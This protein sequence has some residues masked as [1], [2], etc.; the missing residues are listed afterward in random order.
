MKNPHHRPR[1]AVYNDLNT[2]GLEDKRILP[3]PSILCVILILLE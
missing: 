3:N 2:S 1:G